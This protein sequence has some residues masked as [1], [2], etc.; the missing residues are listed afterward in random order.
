MEY[1]EGLIVKES[2]GL[3]YVLCKDGQKTA[4]RAKG[5]FRHENIS[6]TVGDRVI[7][8]SSDKDGH[9]ICGI[10]ERKNLLIRPSLANL[11]RLFIV[12]PAARPDPDLFTA[13]K[14]SAIARHNGIKT[15]IVISK[16][17]LDL[18][19]AAQIASI[20]N[21]ANFKVFVTDGA[22]NIGV[23]ELGKYIK[24]GCRGEIS[25]FA[26]A[27]GVG[28]STLMNLIFKDTARA[29]AS[30]SEKT[31]RGR[32]TTRNVELFETENG[33]FIADT[34]GFTLL[35]FEKFD[36]FELD[37]LTGAFAEL[38]PYITSCKY[39]KCTHTKEEGCAVIDAVKRGE[40]PPS[41]HQSYIALR[42]ILNKKHPWT[43]KQ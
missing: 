6:P 17:A 37:D 11:D 10:K 34:P 4:C 27:S 26:G 43:K 8:D 31:G 12:I 25:A 13:D 40:I 38:E 22:E 42:E 5:I 29:T 1:S 16:C 41:R 39:T 36:F 28:K 7:L 35:D 21:K 14:L 30:V 15:A 3:Y 20:Y 2:G 19:K 33:A 32:H 23:R 18:E 9:V 24:N